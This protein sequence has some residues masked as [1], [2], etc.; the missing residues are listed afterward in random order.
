[1]VDSTK[2]LRF[3]TK[4]KS[5]VLS[6]IAAYELKYAK[7]SVVLK[8]GNMELID[9]KDETVALDAYFRLDGHFSYIDIPTVF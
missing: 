3:G 1:M 9:F 6:S 5:V 8:S 2:P 7:I 4:Y